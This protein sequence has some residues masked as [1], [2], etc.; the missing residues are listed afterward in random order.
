M[1]LYTHE[2]MHIHKPWFFLF[3][4][5]L[6]FTHWSSLMEEFTMFHQI[7]LTLFKGLSLKTLIHTHRSPV[8]TSE[9]VGSHPQYF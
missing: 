7:K 8:Y 3:L 2:H 6:I 1:Y 5:Y 4:D 9:G